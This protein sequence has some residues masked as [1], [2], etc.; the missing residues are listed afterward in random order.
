MSSVHASTTKYNNILNNKIVNLTG[1]KFMNMIKSTKST[2]T[3]DIINNTFFNS[4]LIKEF[5]VYTQYIPDEISFI[6]KWIIF[7]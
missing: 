7:T 4:F 3:G 5:I 1:Y 6:E 2:I